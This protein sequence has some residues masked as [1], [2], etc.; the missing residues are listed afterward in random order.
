MLYFDFAQATFERN[1]VRADYDLEI[2]VT[3]SLSI[4]VDERIVYQEVMFPIVELRVAL[5]RW[6]RGGSDA[7]DFEFVSMESDEVGLV[8]VRHQSSGRWRV[9]SI[10]QD[11]PA[12][13][14]FDWDEVMAAVDQYIAKVDQWVYVHLNL[15][16]ADVVDV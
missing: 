15:R 9:G 14:E 4:R 7:P 11:V 3:A 13:E 1:A 5:E 12:L 2:G 6:T 10:D 16:V 8:W